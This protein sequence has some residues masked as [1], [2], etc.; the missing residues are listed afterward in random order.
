MQRILHHNKGFTL[1]EVIITIIIAGIL[2][3]IALRSV[4]V[5]SDTAKIEQTKA[6]LNN[7]GF[8]IVGNPELENN[9]IRSDFGYVGDVGAMPSNLDAL[10][11]NPGG[12]ATWKG[13]YIENR[14]SQIT[15][16]YKED[17]WGTAYSYSGVSIS[18][19]GSGSG[20]VKQVANSTD[21]ILINQVSGNIYDADGTPP[22]AVYRDSISIRLSIP[23]GVGAYTTKTTI[24]DIGGYFSFDSIPI[25][26]HDID[27]LYTP[28]DDTLNRF[29]SVT[30]NSNIYDDHLYFQC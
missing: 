18:S 9:G 12:Y 4:L 20:I 17:A 16:D 23:N 5:V 21:D 15:N 27:I 28:S 7:I 11:S 10:H 3:A 22:G 29:A 30:P 24:P 2:G 6:E 26:N 19:S 8:A 25:G 1:V 14:F 13:P